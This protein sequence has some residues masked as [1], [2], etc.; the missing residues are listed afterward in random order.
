ML[1]AVCR[2][3]VDLPPPGRRGRCSCSTARRASGCVEAALWAGLRAPSRGGRAAGGHAGRGG[4][5][6]R[7]AAPAGGASCRSAIRATRTTDI[8]TYADA[9]PVPEVVAVEPDD[10]R[11]T[12][13]PPGP[14]LAVV[15][16]P[17]TESAIALDRP[18]RPR[19]AG[20]D[21]GARRGAGRARRPPAA[22]A[23][24]VGG[25]PRDRRDRRAGVRM[26]RHVVPRQL[27]WRAAWAPGTPELPTRRRPAR[28][29]AVAD[30]AAARP[31]VAPVA[32]AAGRSA[33]ARADR[34]EGAVTV[35]APPHPTSPFSTHPSRTQGPLDS[36]FLWAMC[37]HNDEMS[38]HEPT[39]NS[40]NVG[41]V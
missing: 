11:F 19:R 36:F 40:S 6:R 28:G 12:A 8:G 3:V 21:L 2:R 22:V 15:E 26:A 24:D 1:E 7:G 5:A 35:G 33:R 29:A 25:P 37:E 34:E 41:R 20:L 39:T 27:E 31:R 13:P 30:G 9:E 14:V 17:D 23:V 16:A 10:P 4:R 18:R 32:G 38:K